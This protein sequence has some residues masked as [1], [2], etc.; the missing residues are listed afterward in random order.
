MLK[1]FISKHLFVLPFLIILFFLTS[2]SVLSIVRHDNYQSYGYDLGI[3]DQTVWRYAHF[4]L[5]ITT[6]DP[7]PDKSKLVEHIELV[8][9]LIAPSY[10]IWESRKMLLFVEVLAICSSAIPVYL[11]ARKKGVSYILSNVLVIVYLMFYGVQQVMWFDTHSSTYAAAFLMWFIYFLEEKKKWWSVLFFFLAITAKENIGLLTFLVAFVFFLKSR[12]KLYL[13]FMAASVAYVGFIFLVYFPDIVH[14]KY[15]Y[16]NSGGILSNLNPLSLFDTD[17]K[18]QVIWY[19][20]FSFGFL[21]LLSPLTLIPAL[22]DL[23][24][25]FVIANQL[26]GAQGLVGQYRVTLT[27][28]LIWGTVRTLSKLRR[29]DKWYTA[30][31]LI[32]CAISVQY[33]LHEPLSYLTKQWFWTRSPGVANIN[34]MIKN[35]LPNTASVVSQNNIT[36]HISHRDKIFTLYPEKKSFNKNSVCGQATCDWFRW[37]DHPQYLIVDTSPEWDA[38]HYLT[39]REPFLRGLQNIEKAKVVTKYKQIGS[40]ILYKV[41]E[42]PDDVK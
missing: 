24:T 22:G 4:Q 14:M 29:I 16:A 12:R 17:E 13:C 5:P 28:F 18:R 11:L 10:W 36:P 21:P 31:Y 41:N 39:D 32:F 8:Y 38:R 20:L 42:N 30:G 19:S 27:P 6:I 2:Y 1:G 37:Y 26:P 33:V 25:Y 40:T 7:F 23:S 9:A 34:T 15:L 3:N 35:Y